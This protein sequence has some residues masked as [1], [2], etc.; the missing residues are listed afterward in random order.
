MLNHALTHRP[1]V[2]I[3]FKR[4]FSRNIRFSIQTNTRYSDV[5]NSRYENIGY[6]DQTV[7]VTSSNDFA[8][9]FFINVSYRYSLRY[10]LHNLSN[11]I[12]TH[13]L[14]AVA[15]VRFL[16]G[17]RASLSVACYDILNSASAFRTVVAQNYTKTTFSPTFSRYWVLDFSYR[18][19]TTEGRRGSTVSTSGRSLNSGRRFEE[20]NYWIY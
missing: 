6:L 13:S 2:M 11:R 14:N 17:N 8:K 3:S 5:R 1:S 7:Q 18:F 10:P 4:N 19:N 9:R 20:S 16:R 12:D 15:G